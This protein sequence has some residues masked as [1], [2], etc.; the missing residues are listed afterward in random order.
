MLI[1][2][3]YVNLDKIDEIHIQNIDKM[4]KSGE[5]LYKIRQP[6]CNIV[7]PHFRKDGWRILAE[8]A[9]KILNGRDGAYVG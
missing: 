8:K 6:N 9:L 4:L 5:T 1:I 7:V 2:K 3:A